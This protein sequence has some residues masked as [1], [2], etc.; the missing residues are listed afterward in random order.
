MSCPFLVLSVDTWQLETRRDVPL[1]A[2]G[3]EDFGMD[4]SPSSQSQHSFG[5]DGSP[6]PQ[7]QCSFSMG[8]SPSPQ[9]QCSFGMGGLPSPQHQHSFGMDGSS[10]PQ[11]SFGVMPW[12]ALSCDVHSGV[13][14]LGVKPGQGFSLVM[15]KYQVKQCSRLMWVEML[16]WVDTTSGCKTKYE[17]PHSVG[18]VRQKIK[19]CIVER[20]KWKPLMEQPKGSLVLETMSWIGRSQVY[21]TS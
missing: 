19:A 21:C 10:S 12:L 14:V 4:G 13:L 3:Q 7:S 16:S 9:S 15:H 20:Q 17:G 18:Y 11:H 1:S 5:M 8:G 6:S 2:K